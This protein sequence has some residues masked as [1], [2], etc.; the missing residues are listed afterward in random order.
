MIISIKL[1]FYVVLLAFAFLSGVRYSEQTRG[2][3]NWLFEAKEQEIPFHEIKKD[4]KN[5]DEGETLNQ[6]VDIQDDV[7]IEDVIIEEENKDNIIPND[8]TRNE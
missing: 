7:I 3:A 6:E 5:N 1:I 2:V 4:I 8:S